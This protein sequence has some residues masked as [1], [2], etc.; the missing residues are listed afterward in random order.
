MIYFS[1]YIKTFFYTALVNQLSLTLEMF[2]K[3]LSNSFYLIIKRPL[4][5]FYLQ[6]ELTKHLIC[7]RILL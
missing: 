1:C 5:V 7:D 2:S 6:K 3:V 4:G